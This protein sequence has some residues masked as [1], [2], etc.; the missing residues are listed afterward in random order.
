VC[1]SK[2][3]I[4]ELL[5]AVHAGDPHAFVTMQEGVRVYGNFQRKVGE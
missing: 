5:H 2:F 4:E 1:V 3:E